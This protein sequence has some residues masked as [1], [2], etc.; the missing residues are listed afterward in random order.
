MTQALEQILG[1]EIVPS[2]GQDSMYST[3]DTY[4]AG[5]TALHSF[6]PPK[7]LGPLPTIGPIGGVG[8]PGGILQKP[9]YLD[10]G[11]ERYRQPENNHDGSDGTHMNYETLIPG[12]KKPIINIHIPTDD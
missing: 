3:I 9:D 5:T 7:P 12:V 10:G 1:N 2:M 11:I 8:S 4:T 6:D